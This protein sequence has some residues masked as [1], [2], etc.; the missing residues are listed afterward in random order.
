MSGIKWQS[1]SAAFVSVAKLLQIVIVARFIGKE[2][3]GLVGVALLLN[4]F[5]TI[6]VDMGM[7]SAVLHSQQLTKSQ[8]SSFYW[9]NVLSG[10]LF[11]L[12]LFALSP[13]VADYYHQNELVGIV[14][15]TSLLIFFNSLYALQRTM[16]QKRLNFRFISI[17]EVCSALIMLILNLLFCYMGFGVYSYVW[18]SLVGGV[19]LAVLYMFK[20]FIKDHAIAFHLSIS[21]VTEGLK[22]GIYQVGTATLDYFSR[23]M[24]SFIISSAFTM[25]LFGVYTICKQMASRLYMFI[26]PI[27]TSVLTPLLAKIQEDRQLIT[28]NYVKAVNYLGFVNYP[29]YSIMAF[30][31]TSVLFV[32]YGPSYEDFGY[33]LFFMAFFYAF[34]SLGNPQGSLLIATGRTDLGF[35]WTIFRI[36]F[37]VV[38]LYIASRFSFFV[39]CILV[40]CQPLFTAYPAWYI[41]QRHVINITFRESVMLFL[42]PFMMCMPMV[43]LYLIPTIFNGMEGIINSYV[44]HII[45]IVLITVVFLPLYFM[46]NYYFR[47]SLAISVWADVSKGVLKKK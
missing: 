17:A 9:L 29:A 4:G 30:G 44:F 43:F 33:V 26:N 41:C 32:L 21:E 23:E 1:L 39:F 28:R 35:Y 46:M 6:F 20:T 37:T 47:R 3:I 27:V 19:S 13:L 5:C 11:T 16:Q 2:E 14:N 8:F 45:C 34:Q 25:E 22:I 40:F 38:Y 10:I 18:S 36:I 24:D 12:L 15:Y 31:A 7:A 42:R